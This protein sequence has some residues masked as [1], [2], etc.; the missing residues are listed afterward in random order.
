[1][2][3]LL[4]DTTKINALKEDTEQFLYNNQEVKIQSSEEYTNAGDLLKTVLQRIKKLDEKRKE[5]TGPLDDLKKTIMADFKQIS[6]PLESFT[7]VVKEEMKRWYQIE[8]KRLNEEQKRIETE[9]LVK[10]KKEGI[11]EIEVP[12]VNNVAK[13][14]R[15]DY[16]TTT[17]KKVWKWKL[18]DESKIPREYLEIST[19]AIGKAI[20][21]GN[22]D[23]PG[24]EIYQDEQ[25][26]IR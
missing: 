17:V 7:E 5:Y 25:I 22:R 16:A 2:T 14:Q 6:E 13:S 26:S 24:I 1:M 9:A 19:S 12:I 20:S 8:Q 15:G 4:P 21:A 10:A 11:S 18:I 23:I 3:T